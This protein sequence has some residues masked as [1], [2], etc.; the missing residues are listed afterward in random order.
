M[1]LEK[2]LQKK[3]LEKFPEEDI[4]ALATGAAKIA[5]A[6]QEYPRVI[7]VAKIFVVSQNLA[8]M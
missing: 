2:K 7:H 1:C 8:V 6:I 3:G 5:E 4:S